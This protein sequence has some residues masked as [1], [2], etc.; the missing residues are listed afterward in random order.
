MSHSFIAGTAA[1]LTASALVPGCLGATTIPLTLTK[2][3]FAGE[4]KDPGLPS[5]KAMEWDLTGATMPWRPGGGVLRVSTEGSL[6]LVVGDSGGELVSPDLA[7]S[8]SRWGRFTVNFGSN[9][10][11]ADADAIV[12]WTRTDDATETLTARLAIRDDAD[13]RPTTE[14]DLQSSLRWFGTIKTIAIR[15]PRTTDGS[16]I[17][18]RSLRL[19][20]SPTAYTSRSR[21]EIKDL[22]FARELSPFQARGGYFLPPNSRYEMA[23]GPT[24]VADVRFGLGVLGPAG[25]ALGWFDRDYTTTLTVSV[26]APDSERPLARSRIPIVLPAPRWLDFALP[27]RT[28]GKTGLRVVFEYR[29][30]LDRSVVLVSRPRVTTAAAPKTT[31][32]T[33]I[34]ALR[35][36]HLSAYGYARPSPNIGRVGRDGYVFTRAFSQANNTPTAII[37]LMNSEYP[38]NAPWE[39]PRPGRPSLARFLSD[40]SVYTALIT[41]N[42]QLQEPHIAAGFDEVVYVSTR[43]RH[44]S[45]EVATAM[46]RVLRA[47]RGEDLFLYAH[48]IDPHAPYDPPSHT[49]GRYARSSNEQAEQIGT[50]LDPWIYREQGLEPGLNTNPVIP[51]RAL[52]P[53]AIQRIV[54][55]YD[56]EILDVDIHLGQV[57]A[58]MADLG[59][60]DDATLVVSADH[61]EEL[62]EHGGIQHGSAGLY[63]EVVGVPLLVRP[64]RRTSMTSAR[65]GSRIGAL[66]Q[67]VDLYPTIAEAMGFHPPSWVV[68]TNAF[69]VARGYAISEWMQVPGWRRR[70][71]TDGEYKLITGEQQI[72]DRVRSDPPLLFR[73]DNDPGETTNLADQLAELASSMRKRMLDAIRGSR[74]GPPD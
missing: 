69:R 36:T 63:N 57:W 20:P 17:A 60:Y 31:V 41:A 14:V 49:A 72:G 42:P 55:R 58:T 46:V 8:A 7:V 45:E 71:I 37:A 16:P 32:L 11:L 5:A 56:E 51:K 64:G 68:G 23:S 15:F 52:S 44:T 43:G 24:E 3:E 65:P 9:P 38:E 67:H 4:A 73:L 54:D 53:Q 33:T 26:F 25:V 59:M 1:W 66:V 28:S 12:T 29:D 74:E 22:E 2:A 61:G 62:Y 18:V 34:D 21:V 50:S 39:G 6:L 27:V 10:K 47:H 70:A 13:G 48:F 35:K 40:H 19:E 30:E